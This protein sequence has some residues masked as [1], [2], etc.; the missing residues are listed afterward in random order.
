MDTSILH[1]PLHHSLTTDESDTIFSESTLD[2]DMACKTIKPSHCKI[3][4]S[5][6][7]NLIV[8]NDVC[9][10]CRQNNRTEEEYRDSLPIWYEDPDNK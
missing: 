1:F 2:F 5:T 9:T 4:H 10:I 3:C 6:S 7:L 8:S